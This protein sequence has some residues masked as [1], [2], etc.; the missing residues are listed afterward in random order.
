MGD[1]CDKGSLK[2]SSEFST[3]MRV[4]SEG[5]LLI[6][7]VDSAMRGA[8][9]CEA[10]NGIGKTLKKS[11]YVHVKASAMGGEAPVVVDFTFPSALKEGERGSAVCTIRSGDRP[12]QFQWKKAGRDISQDPNIEIQSVKDSSFLIIESVTAQNAGNYTCIV[13]NSYGTDKY[14]ATL[15]VTAPPEWIIEPTD[16]YTQEG[17]SLSIKCKQSGVPVPT[18]KW[19][20]VEYKSDETGQIVS[21]DS[22]ASL[23]VSSD[24]SLV[25]SKVE[26][27]MHG[28]YT[29]EGDNGFGKPL[30]KTIMLFVRVFLFLHAGLYFSSA[31]CH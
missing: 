9:T 29:C 14:T 17:E 4:S 13:T 26:A 7:K 23:R 31:H 11:I 28:S 20:A 6:S 1:W 30:K 15:T 19:I 21:S 12:L 18:I 22:S 27:Y 10:D 3:V 25:F 2:L 24:G 16:I 8:Y 5:S